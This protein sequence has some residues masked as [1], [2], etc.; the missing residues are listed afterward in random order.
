[1]QTCRILSTTK[2]KR[3]MMRGYEAYKDELY[4]YRM[5]LRL[6]ESVSFKNVF[7]VDLTDAL[8]K[9]LRNVSN[10]NHKFTENTIIN[11][12]GG[13]GCQPKN[14]KVL[15]FDGSWKN[16][17]DIKVGD[18]V[19][20]YD[21][22]HNSIKS[23]VLKITKWLSDE[24]Y[25]L[26]QKN[27]H[28]KKLYS[29]SFNHIIPFFRRKTHRKFIDSDKRNTLWVIDEMPAKMF[30]KFSNYRLNHSI[31]GITCPSI[32]NF[33]QDYDCK[34]DPYCLGLFISDG[35]FKY[36]RDSNGKMIFYNVLTKTP[37]KGTNY[38]SRIYKPSGI[39]K[40]YGT[41]A[42]TFRWNLR[43]K[44]TKLLKEYGYNGIKAGKKFIPKQALLSS[45]K[46]RKNLLAGLIDGDGSYEY[47]HYRYCS[48][49]YKLIKQI[50]FLVW[51]IGGRVNQ[52]KKRKGKIKSYGF[53]DWYWNIS[54]FIYEN[55]KIPI[56]KKKKISKSYYK[57]A[58]RMSI[59]AKANDRKN[60]MVYGFTLDSPTGYYI[61]D[62][63]MLTHNSGKSI[64]IMSL[65]KLC[66]PHFSY[67][68]MFFFDQEILDKAQEFPQNTLI[69]RDENPAKG[70]YG[71]GSQRISSQIGVMAETC[72]KAGLNLGFV[73]PDF[74]QS[75]IT[76]I[77][78]ETVDMDINRRITRV[79]VRDT[80]TL[81]YMGA[82]YLNVLD[83]DDEDWLKYNEVK[84]K[85]IEKIKQ[86]KYQGAKLDYDSLI[87]K[88]MKEMD[89]KLY[90]KKKE[91]KAWLNVNYPAL[92]SGEI[93]QILTMIEIE[94]K[95]NAQKE[96][97]R[98]QELRKNS[99]I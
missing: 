74:I 14:S 39:N 20:S 45:L 73:E 49:S 44:F 43:A 81:Q 85:F 91:R 64:C 36:A 15:M 18:E 87:K 40:K 60:K 27:R 51:S 69:V 78:L 72:R 58:N 54:F 66:F 28:R 67:K 80:K 55:Q 68:N 56:Y 33:E 8:I 32:N 29:C 59:I 95:K 42:F 70:I 52:I 38:F 9:D 99:R 21:Y 50:E 86:G 75:G 61:T 84:D 1:M 23:K 22:N 12:S 89:M 62:N 7:R 94:L 6:R 5:I 96:Q 93:D 2:K 63:W 88:C 11:L 48:K 53:E 65:G 41:P 82:L 17:Q 92:T 35:S 47:G 71:V 77:I 3:M 31:M 57:T 16:I 98:W 97:E 4:K 76:K 19:I 13:T 90:A 46:Y 83:E 79:A 10:P 30:A 25:E 24:N 37:S 26:Y 34:I